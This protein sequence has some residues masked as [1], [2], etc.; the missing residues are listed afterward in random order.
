MTQQ[1]GQIEISGCDTMNNTKTGLPIKLTKFLRDTLNIKTFIETGTGLGRTAKIAS[2]M[3]EQVITIEAD[4]ERW[5]H[6]QQQF[7]NTNISCINGKSPNA[8]QYVLK[9][10]NNKQSVIFLDAHC[11]YREAVTDVRCPI[12]NELAVISDRHIIIIDDE[13]SFAK[14][15]RIPELAYD[16]PELSDIILELDLNHNHPYIFI[17]GKAIV[18]VPREIKRQVQEFVN[19][20]N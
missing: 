10:I 8:L 1:N 9:T 16:W 5:R 2:G 11:S 6:N 3:F 18:V 4:Y 7:K 19:A 12:L 13:H 17:E 20:N 14:P 15:H